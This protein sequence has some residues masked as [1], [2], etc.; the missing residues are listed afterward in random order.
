MTQNTVRRGLYPKLRTTG[1][2]TPQPLSPDRSYD[3]MNKSAGGLGTHRL[4]YI[5]N[6]EID[7][8]QSLDEGNVGDATAAIPAMT[9]VFHSIYIYI[10][11]Y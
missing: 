10:Y 1:T 2:G 4:G 5:T 6:K 8:E 9:M 3:L 7:I 11:I